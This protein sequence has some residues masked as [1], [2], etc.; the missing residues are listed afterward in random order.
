MLEQSFFF[1]VFHLF[2]N[3]L[4]RA[5]PQPNIID[6]TASEHK[7]QTELFVKHRAVLKEERSLKHG[8][9]IDAELFVKSSLK[10]RC[11]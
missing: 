10:Q 11:P 2:W 4:C 5:P 3:D 6:M 9:A 7:G 1:Y 8:A